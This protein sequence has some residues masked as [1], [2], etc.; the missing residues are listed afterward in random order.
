MQPDSGNRRG[1]WT[2]ATADCI[3][4]MSLRL[5]VRGVQRSNEVDSGH[6]FSAEALVVCDEKIHSDRCGTGKL[7]CIR[8]L[9]GTILSN[10]G[11]L[12]GRLLVKRDQGR[13]RSQ[14]SLE[15]A[16]SLAVPFGLRL[17]KNFSERKRGCIE[18]VFAGRHVS[19]YGFDTL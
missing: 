10:G 7:D 12:T 13:R 1:E 19:P 9:D 4:A 3:A 14:H 8:R 18:V 17:Y 11:V 15:S 2:S 16:H 5:E 6:Q